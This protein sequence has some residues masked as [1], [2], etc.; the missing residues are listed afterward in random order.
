M[1]SNRAHWEYFSTEIKKVGRKEI[2]LLEAGIK[3]LKVSF[4]QFRRY[5]P[6]AMLK[7]CIRWNIYTGSLGLKGISKYELQVNLYILQLEKISYK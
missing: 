4:P 1:A 3:F 6:T 7:L 5:W 2:P